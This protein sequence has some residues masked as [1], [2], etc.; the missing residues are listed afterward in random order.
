[1]D[2][3][4]AS[5]TAA[6]LD[7]GYIFHR[8]A[9]RWRMILV[10]SL[11][12]LLA[13]LLYLHMA[14]PKYITSYRVTPA[15]SSAT[16][17]GRGLGGLGNI[18]AMA[19]V[20]IGGSNNGATA[21]ELYLDALNSRSLADQLAKDPRIMQ[22]IFASQWD[23]RS[24]NWHQP[25]GIVPAFSTLIRSMLGMPARQWQPPAGEELQKFIDQNV[26]IT[27]PGARDAPITH[28]SMR[29]KDPLFSEYL[30]GRMSKMA[31]T[32]IRLSALVRAQD[33]GK[34]LADKLATT[35]NYE[36]RQVLS[37]ALAEQ[38]RVVMMASSV[39][40]PYSI[41]PLE[42]PSS[43][44]RPISPNYLVTAVAGPLSGF[45]LGLMLALLDLKSLRRIQTAL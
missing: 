34:F 7:L 21:F 45:I 3:A 13:A 19:G 10:L 35:Q 37:T 42:I 26:T 28:I 25:S 20:S 44:K 9:L 12:G 2:P 23:R 14:A 40:T 41:V 36:H 27:E 30:L 16:S 11:L 39:S 6:D 24:K 33:Y 32:R 31:E 29:Y 15:S 38:E 18:A 1:M 17:G 4:E 43:S 22:T 5:D 8:I